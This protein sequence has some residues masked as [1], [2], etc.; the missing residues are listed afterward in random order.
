MG[1]FSKVQKRRKHKLIENDV[2]KGK[3]H[4]RVRVIPKLINDYIKFEIKFAYIKQIRIGHKIY[5]INESDFKK[6]LTKR[7]TQE[8][9]YLFD[10]TVAV[11]IIYNKEGE[12]LGTSLIDN[13]KEVYQYKLLKE[14]L[15]KEAIP[16]TLWLKENSLFDE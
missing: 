3:S 16:L 9:F 10:N 14:K 13:V 12:F 5:V 1:T 6:I 15:L 4:I 7:F 2:K 8:D 11:R